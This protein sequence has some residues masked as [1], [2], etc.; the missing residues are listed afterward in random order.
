MVLF[1]HLPRRSSNTQHSFTLHSLQHF[2]HPIHMAHYNS[3]NSDISTTSSYSEDSN[4][5]AYQL[6]SQPPAV[7]RTGL[8][9]T[10]IHGE[11]HFNLFVGRCLMPESSETTALATPYTTGNYADSYGQPSYAENHWPAVDQQVECSYV[12]FQSWESSSVRNMTQEASAAIPGPSSKHFFY[13][14][15]LRNPILTNHEQSRLITGGTT[16]A[17]PRPTRSTA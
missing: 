2:H 16:E 17:G 9:A 6:L 12:D 10:A 11:H 13:F 3:N 8:R 1:S 15:T 14:A 4:F 5:S 7:G